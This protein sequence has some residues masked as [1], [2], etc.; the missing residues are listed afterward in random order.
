MSG[1]GS[2]PSIARTFRNGCSAACI[3]WDEDP[4]AVLTAPL[5][6]CDVM[7]HSAQSVRA[8]IK[9]RGEAVV[10]QRRNSGTSGRPEVRRGVIFGYQMWTLVLLFDPTGLMEPL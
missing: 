4:S 10:K 6:R 5:M 1:R 9:R 8:S 2:H 7:V 3:R